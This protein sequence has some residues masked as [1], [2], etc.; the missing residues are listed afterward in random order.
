[1]RMIRYVAL[2]LLALPIWR[3]LAAVPDSDES[4]RAAVEK[5]IE[6][7][8]LI[9]Q[10]KQDWRLGKE[11]L[12]DRARMLEKEIAG[13]R[14]KIS[15][16]TNE[17]AEVDRKLAEA[18]AQNDQLDGVS[19]RMRAAVVALE[20]RLPPLLGR[21]PDPVRERLKPLVQRLPQNSADTKISLPE[22]FQSV[23]GILNE[24]GKANGEITV[25]TEIRTM[26]DGRPTQIKA[27]YIGLAQAYYV[28]EKGDAGT[29]RPGA[30]GWDWQPANQLAAQIT[31]AMQTLQSKAAPHFVP[32]PV[33]LP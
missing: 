22:R 14:E 21:T 17:T 24:I 8:R 2:L 26:A 6:S 4:G 20:T 10:E 29:G 33:K 15:T 25:S 19:A 11:L 9:S 18:R 27:L 13:V 28:S 30:N 31:D 1:M 23:I 16:A 5:W 3:S 7:R 32:L 12:A